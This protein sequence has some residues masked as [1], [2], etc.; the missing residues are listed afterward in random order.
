MQTAEETYVQHW[1][2]HKVIICILSNLNPRF[3]WSTVYLKNDNVDNGNF[4]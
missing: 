2:D 1:T 4:T 3:K